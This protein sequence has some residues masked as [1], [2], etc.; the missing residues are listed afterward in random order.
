[1][2]DSNVDGLLSIE[3]VKHAKIPF[4]SFAFFFFRSFFSSSAI[5]YDFDTKVKSN[6]LSLFL[7]TKIGKL[8]KKSHSKI[9]S[10]RWVRAL[11]HALKKHALFCVTIITNILDLMS[12][13]KTRHF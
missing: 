4:P 12:L 8:P 10:E 9:T 3:K 13:A 2:M 1:M 6:F 11:N 5:N 7:Y